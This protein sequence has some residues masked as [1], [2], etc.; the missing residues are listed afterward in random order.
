M[1]FIV[2]DKEKSDKSPCLELLLENIVLYV[3]ISKNYF[4]P[5]LILCSL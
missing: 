2:D 3:Y 1:T 4:P 5:I